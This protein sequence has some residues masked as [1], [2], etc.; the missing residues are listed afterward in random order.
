MHRQV[1]WH[2]EL[3]RPLAEWQASAG[4]NGSPAKLEWQICP[5]WVRGAGLTE[6]CEYAFGQ[7]MQSR[8]AKGGRYRA[9]RRDAGHLPELGEERVYGCR[10]G[11]DAECLFDV[12]EGGLLSIANLH[13]ANTQETTFL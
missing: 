2:R 9:V 6:I 13:A 7:R 1:S 12:T 4:R 11:C 5:T 8:L 3:P 10:L